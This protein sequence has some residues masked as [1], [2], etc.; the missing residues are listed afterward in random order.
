VSAEALSQYQVEQL[1]R[2]PR[3]QT[4]GTSQSEG[5]GRGASYCRV[6]AQRRVPNT[7]LCVPNSPT[8]SKPSNLD[9]ARS[10]RAASTWAFSKPYTSN[11]L[12]PLPCSNL[13]LEKAQT[14]LLQLEEGCTEIAS[15][16]FFVQKWLE[17]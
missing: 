13:P 9:Q 1:G 8:P 17:V 12:S 7:V 15:N 4:E 2:Q 6:K 16:L 14:W 3:A 10:K 11:Y 5:V